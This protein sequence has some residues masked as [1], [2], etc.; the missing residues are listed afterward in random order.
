VFLGIDTF[1]NHYNIE[2]QPWKKK[3]EAVGSV[4]PGVRILCPTRWTVR[5]DTLNRI[6]MNYEFL[7]TFWE[8]SLDSVRKPEMR[9]RITGVSIS[10]QSFDFYFGITIAQV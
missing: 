5:T 4:A 7:Q 6:F 8:E 3:K 2:K 1:K 10:M 9:S